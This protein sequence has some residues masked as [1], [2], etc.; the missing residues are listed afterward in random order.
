MQTR[1]TANLLALLST[2]AVKR[3][4]SNNGKISNKVCNALKDA[5]TVNKDFGL[6]IPAGLQALSSKLAG[7]S[8]NDDLEG[9]AQVA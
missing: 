1:S 9:Q 7:V 8:S 4:S 2:R 3:A 6:D 5:I